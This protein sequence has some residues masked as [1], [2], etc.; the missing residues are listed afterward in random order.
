VSASTARRAVRIAS[1]LAML[2]G[3][4]AIVALIAYQGFA[5]IA[6]VMATAGWGIALV[7]AFHLVPLAA[8]AL[9]WRAAAGAVAEGKIWVFLWAR[10]LREAV[11]GLLPVAQI[12][13]DVVGAR[14]L[15]FHG[16]RAPVAG[17]SVLVDLTLE[18]LTQIV[19]TV[20]GLGLL[21]A[22]GGGAMTGWVV[23]G[24]AVATVAAVGFV[25]AQR[26]GLFLL[27]ERLLERMAGFLNWPALGSLT[28]LH[29]TVMTIYRDRRAM[30][31]ATLWHLAAWF[32]GAVE[33]WLACRILGAEVSFAEALVIES[34]GQAVRTAA[35]FV[36]GAYGVQ[37]GGFM[38]LALHFGLAPEIGLSVSLIKRVRELVLGAPAM[39][40]WQL[41]EGRRLLATA[42]TTSEERS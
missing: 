3:L 2:A 6:R 27:L 12:G 16:S 15:T 26:W 39:L 9:A 4:G 20:I 13:G 17:A 18:F 24:L 14:I 19:F 23:A 8:S 38:I 28:D 35:F 40:A 32:L 42:D 33:V 37:E 29:D 31:G 41:V 36:P 5:D 22:L 7:T 25:L 1:G 34:L 10:L 30:I 11:N 21:L